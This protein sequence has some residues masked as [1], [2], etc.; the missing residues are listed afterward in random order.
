MPALLGL[1]ILAGMFWAISFFLKN[2][3]FY[4]FE[5]MRELLRKVIEIAFSTFGLDVSFGNHGLREVVVKINLLKIGI[6]S[7]IVM[8]FGHYRLCEK[9]DSFVKGLPLWVQIV[10]ISGGVS[11]LLGV[12]LCW[13]RERR[14]KKS[15]LNGEVQKDSGL[16]TQ[17]E[18]A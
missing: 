6:F 4:L 13:K 2:I 1:F 18:K 16:K 9:V 17:G 12:Y 11:I 7:V 5:P 14:L 15:S 8:I 3:A 10:I